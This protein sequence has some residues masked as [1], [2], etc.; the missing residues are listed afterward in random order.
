MGPAGRFQ[1][2]M[3]PAQTGPVTPKQLDEIINRAAVP[4]LRSMPDAPLDVL[5]ALIPSLVRV[6]VAASAATSTSSR[7]GPGVALPRHPD[8]RLAQ[9]ERSR[10]TARERE[11]GGQG[12]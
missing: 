11:V 2:A 4:I 3:S 1:Q 8:A 10:T 9:G 5:G 6:M 12:E 7:Q